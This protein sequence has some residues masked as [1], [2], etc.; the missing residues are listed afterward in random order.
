M[1]Q[2]VCVQMTFWLMEK[3]GVWRGKI[4]PV[5]TMDSAI[6]L[7]SKLKR[8][9]TPGEL[10]LIAV[11]KKIQLYHDNIC[12]DFSPSP[13]ISNFKKNYKIPTLRSL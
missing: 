11:R 13:R 2:G 6:H 7:E 3:V 10:T 9:V 1:Y 12:T 5:S 4:A 8:T